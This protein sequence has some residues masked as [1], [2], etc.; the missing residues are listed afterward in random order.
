MASLQK[1]NYYPG[2]KE[3]MGAACAES[4]LAKHTLAR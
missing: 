3:Q 1:I 4:T 2:F